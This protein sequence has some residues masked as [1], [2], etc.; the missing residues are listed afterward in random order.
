MLQLICIQFSEN[1]FSNRFL[2]TIKQWPDPIP[3][4]TRPSNAALPMVVLV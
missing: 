3:F 1:L 4:R 2:V